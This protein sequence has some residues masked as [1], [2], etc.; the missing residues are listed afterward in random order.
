MNPADLPRDWPNRAQSRFVAAGGLRW[1]VQVAGEGPVLL[2]LHGTGAATHSW[3]GLLPLLARDFT[4]VAPDLPGHGFTERPR[5]EGLSLPGMARG[6]AALLRALDLKPMLAAGH[7]AGAAVTARMTLDGTMA[8]RALVGL[9]AALLPFEG[10]AGQLFSPIARM[11]AGVPAVPWFFAWRAGDRGLVER[12][13]RD[14]GSTVD[15]QGVEFY[16]RLVRRP[17]HVAAALGMMANWEL[18]PLLRDLARLAVPLVLVVGGHDRTVPPSDARRLK[19]LLPDVR[20]LDLPALGH[21]AHEERP[22]EVAGIIRRLAEEMG[23][24]AAETA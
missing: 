15:P 13:L 9:N 16:G 4:V 2:L 12:L 23:V 24:M 7:S 21:L 19:R 1:H 8:P 14:T 22:A 6:V 5:A 18:R 10:I 20:I 3:R 11:L 17:G